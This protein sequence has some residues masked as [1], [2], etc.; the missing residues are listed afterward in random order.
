MC[1]RRLDRFSPYFDQPREYGL[2]NLKPY[3]SYGYVYPF[4]D[5][6]LHEIAYF[7]T[8][9][10]DDGY[11]PLESGKSMLEAV[12]RWCRP[13]SLSVLYAIPGDKLLLIC[14]TRPFAQQ[15]QTVLTTV[16]KEIYLFCDAIRGRDSIYR[17]AAESFPTIR[18][19]EVTA[20]L[21]RMIEARLMLE[22][23]GQYLSLAVVVDDETDL[24]PIPDQRETAW[25]S[26][27]Q[28]EPASIPL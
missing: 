21:A 7:F 12:A 1:A 27:P 11:D 26:L 22:E 25:R 8:F 10:Y 2:T 18:K 4:D 13:D 15:K 16:E 20:F 9:E 5:D 3:P 17:Y 24:G 6:S 19:D 14:D 28:P 23:D